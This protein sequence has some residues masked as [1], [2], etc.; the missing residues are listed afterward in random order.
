MASNHKNELEDQL[1]T[2]KADW[3]Q[4]NTIN[5]LA[6]EMCFNDPERSFDLAQRALKFSRRKGSYGETYLKGVGLSLRTLG[7]LAKMRCDYGIALSNLLE[8]STIFDRL[9]DGGASARRHSVRFG[10]DAQNRFGARAAQHRQLSCAMNF[11]PSYR[12]RVG[13]RR[14]QQPGRR[15]L[16]QELHRAA[17]LEGEPG[18][19]APVVVGPD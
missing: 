9:P 11:T 16:L 18:I 19:D 3:E 7:D 10:V 4:I 14:A 2:A 17:L 8:A 12:L 1:D 6:W 5:V 15:I 13:Q